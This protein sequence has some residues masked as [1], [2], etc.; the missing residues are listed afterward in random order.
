MEP[1]PKWALS[2]PHTPS[3][4]SHGR[5]AGGI[6]A[7]SRYRACTRSKAANSHQAPATTSRIGMPTQI[8]TRLTPTERPVTRNTK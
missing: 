1:L 3:A 6:S 7:P 8:T 2:L 4:R 5:G